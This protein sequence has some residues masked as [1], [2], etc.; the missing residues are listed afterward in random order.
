MLPYEYILS[1]QI[2][3]ASNRGI[4][5]IGSK[6][7]RGRHA[8]AS[9][10][11]QNLFEPLDPEVRE[12]LEHGDGGELN[13]SQDGP[14]KM[15]ALH[16]S[17]ALGVNIFQYWQK[18]G[19]VPVIAAA[20][21]FCRR[22]S[23]VS[24]KIVFEEK[25]PIDEKKLRH[26]PNIDVVIHNSD[27]STVKRFAVECKFTEAYSSRR[28][29][30]IKPKYLDIDGIWHD[31]PRLEHLSR[32]LCPND[33]EFVYLHSAQLVKHI[34]GLKRKFG[35]DGFRLLYL[36]YDALGKEGVDHQKEIEAFSETAGADGIKFH[37]LSYQ[38]LIMR[39]SAE[40]RADHGQYIEYI[41]GRYL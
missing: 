2:Q 27:S 31:V 4:T 26:A 13:R 12:C 33:N 32:S 24:Q 7:R 22:G 15:Q 6:G 23:G 25:Y 35:K 37:S 21:G 5:L 30:G 16:S 41:S 40:Y 28:H 38:E 36:Y 39:L 19:Q 34:L 8:Y 29:L 14:A 9:T 17:S 11:D 1:K 3:W 10:L 18:I 20:C